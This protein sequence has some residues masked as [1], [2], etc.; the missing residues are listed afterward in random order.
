MSN[1]LF[2]FKHSGEKLVMSTHQNGCLFNFH[3]DWGVEICMQ[4]LCSIP[5]DLGDGK[6]SGAVD[7]GNQGAGFGIPKGSGQ[8][9]NSFPLDHNSDGLRCFR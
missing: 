9:D 3:G 7:D 1:E 8:P 2:N 6:V 4:S 5:V